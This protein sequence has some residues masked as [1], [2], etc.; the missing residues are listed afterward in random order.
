MLIPI[1]A[2]KDNYIWCYSRENLP[3]IVIDPTE[4]QPVLDFLTQNQLEVEAILLTH[5]HDDHVGGVAELKK[6]YPNVAVY[7]PNETADKGATVLVN[8]IL[9]RTKNYQMEVIETGGHTANHISYLIDN[10]LFCGDT[11]FCAGCG[12]VFTGDYAQMF[13][14]LQ[15]LNQLPDQVT[16]CPA[17]E[18][19][20]SNL[21]FVEWLIEQQ[22][23]PTLDKQAVFKQIEIVAQQREQHKPT[24]P[25]TMA[26]E[27]Q[28]NPFLLAKS[29]DE[30]TLLRKMKDNF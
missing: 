22:R 19:T 12:R 24:L 23:L 14:S 26:L 20:Q 6:V 13:A 11:L 2:L 15:R 18:Y 28:I 21:A 30:F 5:N 10:H 27:R 17:H 4:S 25:T 7:G 16:V 29:L 9:I 3:V 8:S 1:P